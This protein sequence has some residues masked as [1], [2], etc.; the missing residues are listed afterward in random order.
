MGRMRPLG[1]SEQLARRRQRAQALLRQGLSAKQVAQRVGVTARSI[2]RWQQEAQQPHPK[3]RERGPGRP[4][5]LTAA[6]LQRLERALGR[7]AFAYVRTDR[8]SFSW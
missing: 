7:G 4:S 5:H 8:T 3:H 6:Q 1:T 2:R